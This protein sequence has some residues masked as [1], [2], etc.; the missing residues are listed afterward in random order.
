MTSAT[1]GDAIAALASRLSEDALAHCERVAETAAGLAVVYGADEEVARLAGLLHDWDRETAE[2]ELLESARRGALP[3]TE[4]EASQ[5]GLLHARTGAEALA[6]EFPGISDDVL[7]AVARHTVGEAGMSDMDK[8]V[9]LAD[10][11]EPGRS[12]EGVDDLR[13][14]VGTVSLD[15]LFSLAYQ[16]SVLYLVRERKRIHPDTVAVW[17]AHVARETR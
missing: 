16:H 2:G 10:M 4:A 7:S 12:F 13:E 11:L 17:N 3:V 6:R 8:I 15:E 1:Y 14:G 9:Y 5:P